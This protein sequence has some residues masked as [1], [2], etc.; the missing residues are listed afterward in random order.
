MGLQE[1]ARLDEGLF[2][3]SCIARESGKD[4][5]TITRMLDDA[6][7]LPA[8]TRNATPVYRLRDVLAIFNARS[9]DVERSAQEKLALAKAAESE[10]DRE[11]KLLRLGRDRA[12]LLDVSDVRLQFSALVKPVA[13][14]LDTLPDVLER[15]CE[16]EPRTVIRLQEVI[17]RERTALAEKVAAGYASDAGEG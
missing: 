15:D 4:R 8:G 14:F 7:C 1:V 9:T 17:D 10:V 6:G 13:Q 11:I 5:R 16:L 3:I 12:T 2:S